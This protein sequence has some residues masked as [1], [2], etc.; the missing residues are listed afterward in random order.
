MLGEKYSDVLNLEAEFKTFNS[1]QPYYLTP[2]II[3]LESNI[4]RYF[5]NQQL[6]KEF[7]FKK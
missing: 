3:V 4:L 1:K 5:V 6:V 2:L 7:Y